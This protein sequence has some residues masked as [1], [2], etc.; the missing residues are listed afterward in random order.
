MTRTDPR[1]RWWGWG[2]DAHAGTLPATAGPLLRERLGWTGG[3]APAVPLDAVALPDAALPDGALADLTQTVGAEH[4]RDDRL[5]RVTHAVGKS[6]PDLIRVRSGDGGSAPDAVVYPGD[7][8][9]L[10]AVLAIC[11]RHRIAVT[12]FGGGTSVV[13]GVEPLRDGFAG[14][15]SLD[16]A[17]LDGLLAA[18]PRSQLA[19]L[20]PGMTGPQVEAALNA[21]G[22]TLG[23]FPQSYEY[24][25]LGGWVA[26]R[27]AGQAS[28]GYGRIDALVRG[29]R[30]IAPAGEVVTQAHPGTAAGPQLRELLVGSEG[31][32]GVIAEATLAVRP[33]PS[34]HRYEAV[35]FPSWEAGC[36]AFRA[37]EQANCAPT[38]ARLSDPHESGMQLALSAS[39]STADRLG[40]GYLKARGHDVPCL[41]ILGWEG[42]RR[43]VLARRVAAR[44]HLRA[45]GAVWLGEKPGAKWREGRYHGPY[46]RDHLMDRGVMVE[47]LETATTWTNLRG[48]LRSH[49]RG[50]DRHA[51]RAWHPAAGHVP[52]VAPLSQRRVAV[53]HVARAAGAGRGTRPVAC[54]EDR[55]VRRDRRRR[56][57]DHPS[58][59][60]RDRPRAVAAG[61]DRQRRHRAPARCEGTPR[62]GGDHEPGQAASRRLTRACNT[63]NRRGQVS[64][65][66]TALRCS[67][68]RP[69]PGCCRARPGACTA[70]REWILMLAPRPS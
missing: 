37:L 5:A 43:A 6:Y 48:A 41:G 16:L 39:G 49:R 23:H 60:D 2:D 58:P 19:T 69:D 26:T 54:G 56:R 32:L 24:A 65:C 53:L 42:E 29:V 68:S 36:E 3:A 59:F 10:A 17:R 27:S 44:R 11:G 50:A 12:P 61:G 51:D 30:C 8:A 66:H 18:D 31:T 9:E 67:F 28:T 14:T 55:R 63:R 47:T 1:M 33:L 15:I 13:G 52:R 7:A 20:Q 46:L 34:F 22:L 40:R 38:V 57:H 4:V 64:S 25:T 21:R 62:P 70:P 45:A 35:S